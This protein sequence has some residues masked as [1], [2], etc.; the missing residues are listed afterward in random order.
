M[1]QLQ[2]DLVVRRWAPRCCVRLGISFRL[3]LWCRHLRLWGQRLQDVVEVRGYAVDT[4]HRWILLSIVVVN[5]IGLHIA[6]RLRNHVYRFAC[7]LGSFHRL[8]ERAWRHRASIDGDYLFARSEFSLVGR[9]APAHVAECAIVAD[10]EAKRIPAFRCD[11]PARRGATALG[12]GWVVVVDQLVAAALDA[13]EIGTWSD[14]VDA[15][16]KKL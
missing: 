10:T 3:L 13:F 15:I 11:G 1:L 16:V 4:F 2:N 7:P 14:R 6:F 8:R 5:V 12:C 9:A